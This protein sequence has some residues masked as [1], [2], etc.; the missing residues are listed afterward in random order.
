MVFFTYISVVL[1][2][3]NMEEPREMYHHHICSN[4]KS[5]HISHQHFVVQLLLQGESLD[6]DVFSLSVSFQYVKQFPWYYHHFWDKYHRKRSFCHCDK[7]H[8]P[9]GVFYKCMESCIC[10]HKK[11][12]VK[13]KCFLV[14]KSLNLRLCPFPFLCLLLNSACQC[15]SLLIIF[16]CANCVFGD[17]RF[18][19]SGHTVH[20]RHLA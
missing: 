14:L 1:G 20:G 15:V 9:L 19:D 13:Y 3:F 7:L 12:I 18:A 11:G 17:I 6:F 8:G 4:K 16:T 10:F 5:F 2:V